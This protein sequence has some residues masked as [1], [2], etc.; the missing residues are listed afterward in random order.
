MSTDPSDPTAVTQ[1]LALTFKAGLPGPQEIWMQAGDNVGITAP[2]QQMGTWTASTV[3]SQ[4][5]STVSGTI[6]GQPGSGGTFTYRASSPNGW[7]YLTQLDAVFDAAGS[8]LYPAPHACY[9]G[10]NR[11]AKNLTLMSDATGQWA[12]TIQQAQT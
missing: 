5:P 10:Y 4:G 11:P 3:N 9:V 6:P 7:A 8:T 12:S 2:W 1:H